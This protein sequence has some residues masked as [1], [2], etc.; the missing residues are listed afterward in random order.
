MSR[1]LIGITA[2]A[3]CVG[4]SFAGHHKHHHTV[5]HGAKLVFLETSDGQH[6]K[7]MVPKDEVQKLNTVQPG[8]NVKLLRTKRDMEKLG[9]QG[10]MAPQGDM[11]GHPTF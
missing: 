2:L 9:M 11:T 5:K 10:K 1:L 3:L 6:I 4:T 7:A 8:S